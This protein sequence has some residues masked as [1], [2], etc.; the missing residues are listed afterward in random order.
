MDTGPCNGRAPSCA[1]A[2][3]RAARGK[4]SR[5]ASPAARDGMVIGVPPRDGPSPARGRILDGRVG[6]ARPALSNRARRPQATRGARCAMIPAKPTT[7]APAQTQAEGQTPQIVTS[8]ITAKTSA[9]N[10]SGARRG[11]QA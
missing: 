2:G 1:V 9:E 6:R 4:A 5:A 10:S 3:A 11:A 7:A 8:A